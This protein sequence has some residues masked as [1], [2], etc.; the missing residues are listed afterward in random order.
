MGC[1]M[2]TYF[3]LEAAGVGPGLSRLSAPPLQSAEV[4]EHRSPSR[5]VQ[6]TSGLAWRIRCCPASDFLFLAP[7]VRL[8]RMSDDFCRV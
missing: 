7:P 1:R 5:L 8:C 3:M 2:A 6:H 4:R